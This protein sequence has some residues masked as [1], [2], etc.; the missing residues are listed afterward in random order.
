MAHAISE[1]W[2]MPFLRTGPDVAHAIFEIWPM[3]GPD[4]AQFVFNIG[5]DGRYKEEGKDVGGI[6]GGYSYRAG[7]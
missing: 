1:I 4:V 3:H 6:K 7:K 2:P 5:L